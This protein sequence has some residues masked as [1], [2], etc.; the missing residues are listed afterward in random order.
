MNKNKKIVILVVIAIIILLTFGFLIIRNKKYSQAANISIS[1]YKY[2]VL[3]NNE[4]KVGVIDR[5]GKEIIPPKYTDIYIPNPLKDVFICFNGEERHIVNSNDEEIFTDYQDVSGLVTSEDSLLVLENNVLKYK[6]NELYG[7]INLDGKMLTEPIYEEV[8]SL[9]NRPGRILVKKDDRYGVLDTNGKVV[10]PVLYYSIIGDEYCEEENG[11]QNTGFI[12]SNKSKTGILY[13][14]YN[15][16]GKKILETKYESISR[17]LEYNDNSTYLI[18]MLNGKKGVLKNGRKLIDL[19]Y[20]DVMYSRNSKIFIVNKNGKYGFFAKNGKEILE[21]KY[22]AYEIAGEYISVKENDKNVLYDINGNYIDQKNYKSILEV[23]N[24]S[25]FIAISEKDNSYS[26]LSKDVNIE[27]SYKNIS[28]LFDNLFTFTNQEGKCGIIDATKG[29][30]IDAK[31]DLILKVDGINAIEAREDD[32]TATIYSRD[33]QKIC[34]MSGA[35]VENIN[36]NFAVVYNQTERIYIDLYGNTVENTKVYPND[37]LYAFKKDEKWGFINKEG[38]AII[39]P[40][41]D[42]VTELNEYGFAGIYKDGRWGVINEEGKVIVE[43]IYEIN[44]YYLPK[45]IGKYMYEQT[46]TIHCIDLSKN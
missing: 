15:S 44:S 18:V 4:D 29:E 14:Y 3:Y 43:P 32:G 1:D 46:E 31:Y 20:Q 7:L 12:V 6:K 2:F 23:G 10:V 30:V 17:I 40:E 5:E 24:S 28:Y 22:E 41:Y 37:K 25:Y 34:T 36:K 35:I 11:Y 21:P 26:I 19:N 45:F 42:M 39:E 33:L 38:K 13:G 27:N 16:N 8:S 9:K